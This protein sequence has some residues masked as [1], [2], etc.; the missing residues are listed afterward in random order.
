MGD[1]YV[2]Y[3]N[4]ILSAQV[5][6]KISHVFTKQESTCYPPWLTPMLFDIGVLSYAFR[7]TQKLLLSYKLLSVSITRPFHPLL[8]NLYNRMLRLMISNA[9]EKSTKQTSNGLPSAICLSIRPFNTNKLSEVR[10]P[11]KNPPLCLSISSEASFTKT[12]RLLITVSNISSMIG[13]MV[14][15][16]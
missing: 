7:F 9:F 13:R 11:C 15:P 4:T 1:N 3:N 12:K 5:R 8:N 16:R 10:L 6:S 14:T 2:W